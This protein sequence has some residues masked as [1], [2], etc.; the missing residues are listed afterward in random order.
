MNGRMTLNTRFVEMDDIALPRN[1]ESFASD[2][3][4]LA[5]SA[6][7]VLRRESDQPGPNVIDHPFGSSD[8][9]P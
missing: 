8:M 7:E 4:Q 6:A 9:T 2:D 1:D 3:A 5:L